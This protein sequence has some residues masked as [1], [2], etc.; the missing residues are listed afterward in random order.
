MGLNLKSSQKRKGTTL[1]FVDTVLLQYILG[2]SI[3]MEHSNGEALIDISGYGLINLIRWYNRTDNYWILPQV[4]LN[5][6]SVITLNCDKGECMQLLDGN[7]KLVVG[8]QKVGVVFDLLN[9]RNQLMAERL[10]DFP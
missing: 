7:D 2:G 5:G 3:H 6:E 9:F 8:L 10:V 4:Y 1:N